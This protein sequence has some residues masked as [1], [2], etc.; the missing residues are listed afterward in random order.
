M[1][2]H[3]RNPANWMTA[4]SIACGVVACL[5]VTRG[6]GA[7]A[8]L[9]KV[10]GGLVI[11]AALLDAADGTVARLLE[12]RS[13]FGEMLDSLAD[14]MSFGIAPAVVAYA[15]VL[16]DLGGWGMAVAVGFVLGAVARLARFHD[17]PAVW[18]WPAR[19][20]G[21]PTT[22]AGSATVAFLLCALEGDRPLPP[23]WLAGPMLGILVLM[24]SDLPFP[25][26]KD[27]VD[28]RRS[29]AHFGALVGV[30][31]LAGLWAGPAWFFGAGGALYLVTGTLDA[32]VL[33]LRRRAG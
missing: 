12:L 22:M 14:A 17:P 8:G 2:R 4:A 18:R 6:G 9:V 1:L 16:A 20:Q 27:L 29:L 33:Q 15:A 25:T 24:L 19:S 10:A 30:A 26:F 13:R 5:L 21:L 3:L 11:V 23:G 28:E 7:D 32:V 31:A